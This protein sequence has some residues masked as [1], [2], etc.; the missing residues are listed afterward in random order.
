[1]CR[2]SRCGG[3]GASLDQG[4]AAAAA[5][6]CNR[7]VRPAVRCQPARQMQDAEANAM[8]FHLP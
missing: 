8:L 7:H 1:M 2:R 5:M 6:S 4:A 3:D